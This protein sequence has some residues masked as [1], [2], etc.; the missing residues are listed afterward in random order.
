MGEKVFENELGTLTIN[1]EVIAAHAG[2]AALDCFGIVGMAILNVK[3]G[4]VHLLK[5]E[6]ASRG[7]RVIIDDGKLYIEMH[8]IVAYGVNIK[9]VTDNLIHS[10]TYNIEHFTGHKVDRVVVCVDSVRVI[11]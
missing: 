11:D 2:M 3:D 9:T 10:V 1:Q 6:S 8:I 5:K 4:I 7:V